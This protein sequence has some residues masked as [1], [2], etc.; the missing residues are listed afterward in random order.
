M[1]RREFL[2]RMGA[3]APAAM[4]G[5]ATPAAA[6][7]AG[8]S[9]GASGE[10]RVFMY[11]DGR[12]SAPLYQFA[13]PLTAEDYL[14]TVDLLAQTGVD[15]LVSMVGLEGGVALYDS[16]V[17][18]KWGDNMK[19]WGHPIFYRAARGLKQLI[20]DGHDPLQ[21]LCDRCHELGLWFIAANW[22]S[23]QSGR[24]D[25]SSAGHG[26][27]S[28]FSYDHPEYHVGPDS[29]PRAKTIDPQRFSLLYDE[30]REER[31]RVFEEILD[32]YP[33]DGVEV[34]LLEMMPGCKFDQSAR[35]APLLTEWFRRLRKAAELAQEKQNRRKRIYV[36]IPVYPE[37][38]TALGF[39]VATW[40]REGLVDGLICVAGM[41]EAPSDQ[42]V[43]FAGVRFLTRGTDCKVIFGFSD[44]IYRQLERATTPE[45][46]WAAAANGYDR[47]ADGF[48]IVEYH[49]TPNGWPWQDED[50]ATLRLLQRPDLLRRADKHYRVRSARRGRDTS[51]W[52]PGA[53]TPLPRELVEGKPF[54]A[55]FYVSDDVEAA[56]AEGRLESA[57]LRVRVTNVEP[58]L[59]DLRVEFNGRELPD[60]ILDLNDVTYRLYELGAFGPYGFIYEF[61][62]PP[63][64]LPRRGL[65]TVTVTL[66][67]KDPLLDNS[68]SVYDIDCP[69]KYREHR[70][71]REIPFD[72]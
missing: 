36:R 65:N 71:F 20:D 46:I 31:F 53:H 44:I 39:D 41:M 45:M 66:V 43:D 61:R 23:I 37:A 5:R 22:L 27:K 15:T 21:L 4:V 13:P 51:E 70:H 6:G 57:N 26:R 19:T 63:D 60:T 52:V 64:Q 38:W 32:R 17:C 50:F 67:K 3:V 69:V 72:Y 49:F 62:L 48:A 9:A 7:T 47:G 34:N 58:S 68:L 1:K 24:R 16:H 56:H 54:T 42:N 40:V 25:D 35:L 14:L 8:T 2:Q 29:D 12:H 33:V 28:D 11:D 10:P 18:Q 30:V 59:N 55:S